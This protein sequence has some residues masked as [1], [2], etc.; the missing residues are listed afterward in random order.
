M[1]YFDSLVKKYR[2]KGILIDTNLLIG[3]LVGT[4]GPIHLTNCRATKAFT[5]EDFFLLKSFVE[6]FETIISTPHILTEVSN[7]AGRLPES[8]TE[9][10][11]SVFRLVIEK[12][13]ENHFSALEIVRDN[14]FP[15]L[16][17]TDTAI[18]M[19]VP[20]TYLV[21]TD[22]LPL[23]GILSTRKVDVINFNHIRSIGWGEE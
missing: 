22:E 5:K 15:R 2:R 4:L 8:L 12:L 20:G 23:Y 17:I 1:N 18:A 9:N 6:Q 11:R 10:F 3:L 16:G 21:L 13:A 19:T 14:G 7:L